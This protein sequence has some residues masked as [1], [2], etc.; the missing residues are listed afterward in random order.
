MAYRSFSNIAVAQ[1]VPITFSTST[2][3]GKPSSVAIGA[4]SGFSFPIYNSDN[5]ELFFTLKIPRRWD[6]TTNPKLYILAHL[7]NTE[8]VGDKFQFQLSYVCNGNTGV[9]VATTNDIPIETTVATGR[10]AQYDTY[11]VEFELDA[12]KVGS[13]CEFKGRL[14]RIAASGSEVS[15]EIIVTSAYINFKRDKLGVNWS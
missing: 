15:N 14:R 10:A 11:A 12:T 9:L 13:G 2:G 1:R 7:V 6:G 8:D 5:E 3:L 4:N